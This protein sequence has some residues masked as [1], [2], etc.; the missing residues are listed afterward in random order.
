MSDFRKTD[1]WR[2]ESLAQWKDGRVLP[3]EQVDAMV[4]FFQHSYPEF[5]DS[6]VE[7]DGY[8]FR[9]KHRDWL[10][11]L[12]AHQDEVRLVAFITSS[13]PIRCMSK[14]RDFLRNGGLNWSRD[15]Y[16]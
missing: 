8:T 4:W 13:T 2:E 3:R 5:V 16:Q 14:C 9:E 15:K 11:V 12:K 1:A 7:L 6:G 10:M